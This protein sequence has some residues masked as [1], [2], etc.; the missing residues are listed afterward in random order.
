MS[1]LLNASEV[2]LALE[3]RRNALPLKDLLRI[4]TTGVHVNEISTF[5]ERETGRV[6]LRQRQPELAD[7]LRRLL[8]GPDAVERRSSGCSTSPPACC[9]SS[10]TLPLILLTAIAVKLE[11]KGPAFYRQRRVGLYGQAFDILKLRSMRQDA[12]VARQGGLGGE[13]RS[14]HHPRRPLHPQGADRRAAA[15]LDAC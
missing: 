10:L 5:L 9:C 14:A 1:S 4:K 3:E 7:L 15:M 12:E 8:V 6:D 11:S 13:G 2:V